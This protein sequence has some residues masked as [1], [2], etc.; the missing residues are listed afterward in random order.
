MVAI[1][2]S[3]LG[4]GAL[5]LGDRAFLLRLD[6]DCN[7]YFAVYNKFMPARTQKTALPEYPVWTSMK[8]R[9]LNPKDGGYPDYGGRGISVCDRWRNSF[10]AF[11]QD[12]GPRP[13]A[14]HSIDRY[15]DN[16]GDYEPGN[17]RWA[18]RKEQAANKRPRMT[19][20]CRDRARRPRDNRQ[21]GPEYLEMLLKL[22]KIGEYS[23]A[24]K[25]K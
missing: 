20:M 10:D 5:P 25:N 15:P 3:R 21:T 19:M 6:G 16:D 7:F 14:Q 1:I 22:G 12:M 11:L 9:C 17:C 24:P 13:S 2:F 4:R 18:T 8:Q 23:K